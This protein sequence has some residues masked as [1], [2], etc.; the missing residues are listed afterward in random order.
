MPRAR[1]RVEE[2]TGTYRPH[3]WRDSKTIAAKLGAGANCELALREAADVLGRAVA[4][5][6]KYS[7]LR[8]RH[9][10]Q[11]NV[12]LRDTIRHLRRIVADYYIGRPRGRV[13]RENEFIELCL[14]D[15]RLIEKN[16]AQT[17]GLGPNG[18][19]ATLPLADTKLWH[20]LRRSRE[21]AA[22]PPPIWRRGPG[23]QEA[24]EK[25]ADR[26]IREKPKK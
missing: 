22:L 23:R 17:L 21:S 15:A 12:L 6:P 8:K 19:K 26:V 10:G 16:G 18:K 2:R 20:D 25:I 14:I 3:A 5:Q 24:I 1:A 4:A 9:G 11:R 13:A 7:T